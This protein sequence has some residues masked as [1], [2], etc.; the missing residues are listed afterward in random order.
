VESDPIGLEG[1]LSTYLY[2]NGSP[3]NWFDRFGLSPAD[4]AIILNRFDGTV[5]RMTRDGLRIDNWILNNTD[6][7][8]FICSDQ[9]SEVLNDLTLKGD[10]K[11]DDKWAF[12]MKNNLQDKEWY[13]FGHF[14]V[15]GVSL[16]N[17]KDPHI[18]LDPWKRKSVLTYK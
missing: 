7:D 2:S 18:I 9:A 4:V 8:R 5:N 14:W 1:G 3:L 17:A 11:T 15:E 6:S 10:L 16:T 12:S 13:E